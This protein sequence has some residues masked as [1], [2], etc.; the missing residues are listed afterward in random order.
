M[1]LALSPDVLLQRLLVRGR[2]RQLQLVVA[3]A[4]CGSVQR[5][6]QALAMSQPAATQSLADLEA[7]VGEALFERHARGVRPTRFGAVVLPMARSVVQSL[8]TAAEAVTTLQAGAHTVLRLGTIAAGA[9]GVLAT[10]LPA[11]LASHPQVQVELVEDHSRQLL[12]ELAAGRLDAVVGRQP[13]PPQGDWVFLPLRSDAPAL[14]AAPTHPLAQ[15]PQAPWTLACR[16]PWL[17]PHRGMALREHLAYLW[18][19]GVPEHPPLHPLC[20]TSLP[21]ILG[22]L[23]DRHTIALSPR[24]VVQPLVAQGLLTRLDIALPP[25]PPAPQAPPGAAAAAQSTTARVQPLGLLYPR[26]SPKPTLLEDLADHLLA[27]CAAQGLLPEGDA[28]TAGA[29]D[30]PGPADTPPPAA[31]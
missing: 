30:A 9:S 8:R 25:R 6:A 17:L 27:H 26:H 18:G 13:Q 20:T 31:A 16:H 11:W 4:D 3:L 22:V 29:I 21:I 23:D 1:S 2:L 5:A 19:D 14:V 7:L 12:A 24:S 28:G 10:A 15:R